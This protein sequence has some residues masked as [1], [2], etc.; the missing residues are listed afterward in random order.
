[1]IENLKDAIKSAIQIEK[2]GYN[3]YN[4]ASKETSNE[5]AVSL[6]KS[7]AGDELL[8]LEIFQKLFK[9]EIEKNEWYN[10]VNSGLKYKDISIFPNDLKRVQGEKADTNEIDALKIAI[11]NEKR[12][13]DYYIDMKLKNSDEKFKKIINEIIN[14]EKSHL[15]ILEEEFS[16]ITDTGNWFKLDYL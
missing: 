8:H 9:Q 13:I 2:D 3:F 15:K 6:F 12:S 4:K 5:M 7:L 10:L 1:M 11:D 16:H 14:Q